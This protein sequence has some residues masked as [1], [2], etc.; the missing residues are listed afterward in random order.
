MPSSA[1]TGTAIAMITVGE[2]IGGIP[3]GTHDW[4][5]FLTP[6]ELTALLK[7]QPGAP[8]R[9]ADVPQGAEEADGQ[10]LIRVVRDQAGKG[11][12]WI[13][14]YGDYRAGPRGEAMPTFSQEEM[15]LIVSTARM[16]RVRA[17]DTLNDTVTVDAG[18]VLADIQRIAAEHDRLF[19]LSL[20]AEGSCQIG[21][22]LSTNAGGMSVLRYGS[23]RDQ[24][25]ALNFGRI[26]ARG[27]SDEVRQHP[28]VIDAWIGPPR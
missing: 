20:G 26:I 5:K 22:N 18:V 6:E 19:P 10:N 4:G 3:K 25:L 8:L 12:D 1:R 14:V 21:G 28:D 16:K 23:M 17:V 13:K 27:T 15:N 2:S 9:M 24:V 7:V 11:A